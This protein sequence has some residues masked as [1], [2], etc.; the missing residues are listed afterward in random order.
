[1]LR[2]GLPGARWIDPENYHVTLRFIGDIDE[3]MAREMAS[4]LD[5]MRR[6]GFEVRFD[7]LTSFG[8]NKPRAVVAAVEP[9]RRWSSCRPSRS[10]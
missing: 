4:M 1:M 7:G 2:G 10:G 9:I 8:G 3:R 5:G 6:R